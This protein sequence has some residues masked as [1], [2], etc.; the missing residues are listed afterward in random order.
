MSEMALFEERPVRRVFHNEEWWFVLTDIVSALT[1]SPAPSDYLKKLRR[2]DPS[3]A[4]AFKGGGQFV[5]PLALPFETEGGMQRLQCWNVPGVLRLIQSIPSPKAEPFKRWLA[6][7]GYERLQEIADPALALERTRENWRKLGRSEKW[8]TQRMT[9]YFLP[10]I[11]ELL[12]DPSPDNYLDYLRRK[13][14]RILTSKEEYTNPAPA[15]VQK[16][17]VSNER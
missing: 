6:K 5:P 15:D 13:L 11:E 4:E 3:L 9:G 7:V 8:I 14:N 1:D 10:A 12:A 16:T 2:R 17:T